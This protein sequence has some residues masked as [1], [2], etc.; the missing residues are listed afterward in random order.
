[1]F[2]LRNENTL[3]FA[4]IVFY[5]GQPC[6]QPVAGDWNGDGVDTIGIFRPS[7]GQFLLRNSNDIGSA[8]M[9]WMVMAGTQ[10]VS[11]A[12]ATG[13]SFSR[14]RIPQALQTLPSTTA[15]RGTSQ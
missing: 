2:Y 9:S 11:S 13:L 15:F 12:Q 7:T 5:F 3:G 4:T 14:T 8:Q 10:P 6:D 1:M